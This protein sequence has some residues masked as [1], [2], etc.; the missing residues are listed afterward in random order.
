MLLRRRRRW[1]ASVW[2]HFLYLSSSAYARMRAC[3]LQANV[4][5]FRINECAF[6]FSIELR[7]SGGDDSN[8]HDA[9]SG[10][11]FAPVIIRSGYHERK[12]KSAAYTHTHTLI[13]PHAWREAYMRANSMV[14]R[15][16]SQTCC[17]FVVLFVCVLRAAP[18]ICIYCTTEVFNIGRPMPAGV[19]SSNVH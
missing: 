12:R 8:V 17:C 11:N 9:A 6:W 16:Q 3:T 14:W 2:Y 18:R 10:F 15:A 13:V 19:H 4:R 5:G 7:R 1:P